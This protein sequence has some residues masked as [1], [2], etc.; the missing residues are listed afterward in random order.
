MLFLPSYRYGGYGL[1]LVQ[2]ILGGSLA[3]F[4]DWYVSPTM[5]NNVHKIVKRGL[6]P[7][8]F[9]VL[10]GIFL[11]IVT[12]QSIAIGLVIVVGNGFE[13]KPRFDMQLIWNIVSTIVFGDIVFTV[14]HLYFLHGTNIGAKIHEIH[15]TCQPSSFS[16][17][18]IFHFWDSMTEFTFSHVSMAAYSRFF[19][20]EDPFAFYCTIQITYLWYTIVDHS[21]NIQLSHYYHHH[22]TSANYTAYL[23]QTPNFLM[24]KRGM[25]CVRQRLM[26]HKEIQTSI[27]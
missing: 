15:H 5:K 23:P 21:E 1:F 20:R 26:R 24:K 14:T 6:V 12:S 25:D 10:L 4:M 3:C 17:S 11:T 16:T 22:L 13:A 9:Q 18:F 27:K 19:H 8:T 2:T 7:S